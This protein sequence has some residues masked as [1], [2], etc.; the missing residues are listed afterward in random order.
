MDRLNSRPVA[1][2]PI[3]TSCSFEEN[4]QEGASR[5]LITQE[6]CN[7]KFTKEKFLKL[8]LTKNGDARRRMTT[9]DPEIHII[10]IS[11]TY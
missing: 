4:V 9:P 6:R 8:K 5:L 11:L 3:Q 10:H 1:R 7:T 2:A